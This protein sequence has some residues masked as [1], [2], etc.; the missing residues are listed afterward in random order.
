MAK[1]MVPLGEVSDFVAGQSIDIAILTPFE[2]D[3]RKMWRWGPP[4]EKPDPKT[5]FDSY[6]SHQGR[7]VFLVD[8]RTEPE[9][10]YFIIDIATPDT[11][12][13]NPLIS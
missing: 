6:A 12:L 9:Y 1:P 7:L 4:T 10:F 5:T 8:G 3:G 11:A 13:R 2:H